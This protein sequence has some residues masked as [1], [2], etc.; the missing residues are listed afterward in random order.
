MDDRSMLIVLDN[1]RSEEQVRPLLPASAS[2]LVLVTSRG[3]LAG[4]VAREGARRMDLDLLTLA[5]S[6][7]LLRRLIGSRVDAEPE[8]AQ[9]LAGRCAR[10]PLALRVVAERAVAR[11]KV[12]LASLLTELADERQR[13]DLLDAGGDAGTAVRAVLSWSYHGLPASA[14]RVFRILG[15]HPGRTSDV[16]TATA[17]ASVSVPEASRLTAVLARAHLI[18]ERTHGQHGMHDLLRD[19]AIELC[20][21]TDSTSDRRTALTRL[22]TYYL[23]AA[24]TAM[25]VLA[26]RDS[27]RR[28]HLIRTNA[29]EVP[30]LTDHAQALAWIE[31]ERANI[32]ATIRHAALDNG[33]ERRDYVLQMSAT[34]YRYFETRAY[35]DDALAVHS[36]ALGFAEKTDDD[37]LHAKALADIGLREARQIP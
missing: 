20:A 26:P 30:S 32:V 29:V 24:C 22:F 33:N 23:H 11:P 10:L 2:C 18:D 9:A 37:S 21:S 25:N 17:L 15:I 14:A 8:A 5:E 31:S 34:L 13:L 1:A 36:L 4:L 16:Y 19:Y 35:D 27:Y 28:P 12:P 3:S 7:Q 6:V